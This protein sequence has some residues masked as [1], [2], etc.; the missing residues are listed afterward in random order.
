MDKLLIDCLVRSFDRSCIDDLVP[1]EVAL[2]VERLEE[3]PVVAAG[4]GKRQPVA[5]QHVFRKEARA[6]RPDWIWDTTCFVKD[7]HHAVVVMHP[8]VAVR[9]L[10]RPQLAFGGPVARSLLQVAL[11]QLTYPFGGHQLGC[12]DFPP[13]PVDDHRRPF[14]QLAPRHRAQLRF[15]VSRHNDGRAN[16]RGQHPQHQPAHQCRLADTAP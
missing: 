1:P 3:V 12:A 6:H 2:G 7:Q 8:G 16:L 4:V 13:M 10:F 11:D 5:V 9:V 14:G 15:G